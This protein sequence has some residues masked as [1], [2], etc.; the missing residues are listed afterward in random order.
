MKLILFVDKNSNSFCFLLS[1]RAGGLG[2]NLASAD[3]V[4]IYD[5]DW[6]PHNDIQALSRAHRIGQK[7]KVMIYRFVCRDSVEE[8]MARVAKKKMMLSELIVHK[9]LGNKELNGKN[10]SLSKQEMKAILKFGAEDLFK[11]D[12]E[13]VVEYTDEIIEEMLNRDQVGEEEVKEGM[14]DFLRSFR[15]ASYQM[16]DTNDVEKEI[17]ALE[18]EEEEEKKKQEDPNYWS[19]LLEED[20]L[21]QIQIEKQEKIER[22]LMMGRGKR[23]RR[24]VNYSDTTNQ[25][26][27]AEDPDFKPYHDRFIKKKD[28]NDDEYKPNEEEIRLNS[29]SDYMDSSDSEGEKEEVPEEMSNNKDAVT[30]VKLPPVL[31]TFRGSTYVLGF[32]KRERY[33]FTELVMKYGLPPDPIKGSAWFTKDFTRKPEK[34]MRAYTYLFLKHLNEPTSKDQTKYS[35][36]TPVDGLSAQTIFMRLGMLALIR[37]KVFE[38][39]D[40]FGEDA[41]E[42]KEQFIAEAKEWHKQEH[43]EKSVIN[44]GDMGNKINNANSESDIDINEKIAS[45]NKMEKEIKEEKNLII[46][47]N[48]DNDDLKI[49]EEV[50]PIKL[51]RNS[52]FLSIHPHLL[53]YVTA[54]FLKKFF[55][56]ADGNFSDITKV[57]LMEDG[58]LTTNN[59][60]NNWNRLHDYWLLNGFIVYVKIL[61]IILFPQFV[62][63]A[64]DTDLGMTY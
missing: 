39:Q 7:N 54:K 42:F 10:E 1:T 28:D 18:L 21:Q 55:T 43:A 58:Y 33:L 47:S 34:H 38:F 5:M 56:I 17:A 44:S 35:D 13:G 11:D 64:T 45:E 27:D 4:I 48:S 52:F 50:N 32:S 49:V 6:N 37:K 61:S 53:S 3:T 20:H 2:I 25:K 8:K 30:K 16:K 22:D 59:F 9:N 41:S 60:F 26:P 14:N 36:G 12:K 23:N 63:I 15:V 57:W 40:R 46:N 62:L 24:K 51:N 31:S 29:M 19:R